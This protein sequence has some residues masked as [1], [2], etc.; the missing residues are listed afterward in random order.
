[1]LLNENEKEAV[2]PDGKY[3]QGDGEEVLQ[4]RRPRT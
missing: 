1:L 2:M 3:L 4:R